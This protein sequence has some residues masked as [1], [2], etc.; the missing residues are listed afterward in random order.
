M[1]LVMVAGVGMYA[2]SGAAV[3]AGATRAMAEVGAGAA[4]L[5]DALQAER[6]AV[7]TVLSP[8]GG[9]AAAR[10]AYEEQIGRTVAAADR[11]ARLRV[12]L[13]SVPARIREVLERV[14]GALRD[15][16]GQRVRVRAGQPV[17]MS[18]STFSYRI[19]IAAL[20]DYREAVAQAAVAPDLAGLIS[21]GAALSRAKEAV[22]LEQVAV[23]QALAS[24][25]MS[26]ALAQNVVA[27]R[28]SFTGE[29]ETFQQL[30]DPVWV[31]LLQRGLSGG[32]VLDATV[33]AGGVARTGSSAPLVLPGGAAAWNRVMSGRVTRLRSVE[34]RVDADVVAA[35]DAARTG[36]LWQAAVQAVL[37][38][39]A[40]LL[41][42]GV[43]AMVT[44]SIVRRVRALQAGAL[45][46]G[47]VHLPEVTSRLRT[48]GTVDEA[49]RVADEAAAT[50]VIGVAGRDEIGELAATFDTLFGEVL[51]RSSDLAVGRITAA[52]QVL[53]LSRRVQGLV[54]RQLGDIDALEDEIVDEDTLDK[55]F[56][57]DNKAAQ[58]RRMV[59]NLLVL[60]GG[61]H[62]TARRHAEPLL[63]LVRA[64]VSQ[65]EHY[66][67]VRI[68]ELPAV[69]VDPRAALAVV[70][71]VAELVDNA[72][73]YSGK[74]E[75]VVTGSCQG[76]M[77][78]LQVR[79]RGVGMSPDALVRM[80]ALLR[81]PASELGILHRMG[82]PVVS[83]LAA[84]LDI[85][86]RLEPVGAAPGLVALVRVPAV[87]LREGP[88]PLMDDL[89]QLALPS[90]PGLP[91]AGASAAS[92]ASGAIAASGATW[93]PVP[94]GPRHAA[95]E[96]GD[97][98]TALALAT[99]RRRVQLTG[100]EP[101]QEMAAVGPAAQW[102][103]GQPSHD[104]NPR[105]AGSSAGGTLAAVQVT[106]KGLP[107]RPQE[108]AAHGPNGGTA[109]MQRRAEPI[110][111][112]D[113]AAVGAQISAAVQALR[114]QKALA[115]INGRSGGTHEGNDG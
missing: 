86:V 87:L 95:A 101:T 25:A 21:A 93:P 9:G 4:E 84:P 51:R 55:L 47:H 70:H 39:L 60:S 75:V 52:G 83:R 68:A 82:L 113:P 28:A 54:E 92:S 34:Q 12:L 96:D 31:P 3:R 18:T 79:D 61:G 17:A 91:P 80:N 42:L 11:F 50:V 33:L 94:A 108:G 22:G 32:E 63:D 6:V 106:P 111:K 98:D 46:I 8:G 85:D 107:R 114:A 99:G 49:R 90:G 53:T 78:F 27:A 65:I 38:L 73:M 10:M 105:G 89:Q 103:P 69:L 2:T 16:A 1:A 30:A 41:A 62:G 110:Q 44:R 67:R 7:A 43:T 15:V 100:D 77:L 23:L 14:D 40:L 20:I 36:Q 97:E 58:L 29:V 112:R 35:A 48:V 64:A 104:V 74:Y 81:D 76:G 88:T 37:V 5:T 19:A 56:R 45:R 102:N 71:I 13:P 72:T 24:G 66:R 115:G 57:V 59:A 109:G 26:P